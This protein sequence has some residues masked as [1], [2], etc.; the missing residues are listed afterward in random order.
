MDKVT[1]YTTLENQ[2]RADGSK[3][4]LY[5]HYTDY[6]QACAKYFTICAA[7]A[8]SGLPYHSAHLLQDDGRMVRQEIF[9]RRTYTIVE[10]E[11]EPEPEP[12][13]EDEN[14]NETTPEEE[15]PEAEG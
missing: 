7:A 14:N 6:D 2:I 12:E 11:P 10:P 5:D 8:V 3:G 9:D 15:E 1:F 4:L 13:G